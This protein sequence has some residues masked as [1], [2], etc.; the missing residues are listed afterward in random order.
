MFLNATRR[1]RPRVRNRSFERGRSVKNWSDTGTSGQLSSMLV[2]ERGH[3]F[4]WG[5]KP[6]RAWNIVWIKWLNST[7]RSLLAWRNE[8][9]WCDE[10]S[11]TEIG[12][13][14]FPFQYTGKSKNR[15]LLSRYLLCS[16]G[17]FQLVFPHSFAGIFLSFKITA[18]LDKVPV[19]HILSSAFKDICNI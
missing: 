3:C 4:A 11:F 14:G 15:D 9:C 8:N 16:F 2:S 1:K 19:F 13:W 5:K 7:E 10:D 6:I 18:V 12:N 17:L